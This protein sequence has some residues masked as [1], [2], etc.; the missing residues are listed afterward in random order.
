[1]DLPSGVDMIAAENP[2]EPHYSKRAGSPAPTRRTSEYPW[3]Q[4]TTVLG[5]VPQSPAST[6]ASIM[7]SSSSLICQPSVIG[8]TA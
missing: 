4:S 5:S 8:S 1:M 7:R 3:D 2:A 6:T